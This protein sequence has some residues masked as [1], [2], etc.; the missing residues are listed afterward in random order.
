MRAPLWLIALLV[1]LVLGVGVYAY[2]TT[3]LPLGLSSVIRTP[4]GSASA[5]VATALPTPSA[6]RVTAGQSL[7]LGALTVTV[8]GVQRAQDVLGSGGRGPS[9]AF[10]VVLLGMRNAGDQPVSMQPTDFR[11]IDDRGRTYAVDAEATRAASQ[12]ARRRAPFDAT[13][14]PGGGLETALAFETAAD[15]GGLTLLVSLGY[16]E[17]DLPR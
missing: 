9:G 10:T 2:Y 14:P 4:G 6:G 12:S 16:G 15:A 17:L 13:V 8:E 5:P 1:L 11:L 7:L 3:P